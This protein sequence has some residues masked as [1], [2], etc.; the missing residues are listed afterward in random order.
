MAG[1]R[2]GVCSWSIDRHDVVA[3]IR[4]ARAEL[5]VDTVQVGFFGADAVERADCEAIRAAAEAEG[6][7]LVGT[8]IGFDGEDYASIERITETG[9][10]TPDDAYPARLALARRVAVLTADLGCSRLAVHPAT[11]PADLTSPVYAMLVKRLGEV[12]DAVAAHGVRLLLETGREPIS[13]LM[14]FIG[15][16]GRESVAVSFDPGNLVV[17]GADDPVRA[18]GE[19]GNLIE[20][21]HIKDARRSSRPGLDF[22][23]AAP[24]GQG[25]VQIPRVLDE[26]AK[27]AFTGPVLLEVKS[28]PGD[29]QTVRS[30]IDF[31]RSILE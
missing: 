9:G 27:L 23:Q 5:G 6:V 10:F 20:I 24:V 29:R 18:V 14:R 12:A 25:D 19:L 7:S 8:F 13:T 11:I 22:G 17:Y 3:A 2:I 30:A 15:D 31:V 28:A 1:S 21:V 16:V 26:L 4:Q